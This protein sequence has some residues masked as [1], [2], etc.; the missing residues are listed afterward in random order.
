MNSVVL[1]TISK[2]HFNHHPPCVRTAIFTGWPVPLGKFTCPHHDEHGIQIN[3]RH[4]TQPNRTERQKRRNDTVARSCWSLYLGSRFIR[5]C[6][7]ADSLNFALAICFI[8][9]M[10]VGTSYSFLLSLSF[11]ISRN[12]LDLVC[13][14]PQNQRSVSRPYTTAQ[15]RI[16]E[17]HTREGGVGCV[18]GRA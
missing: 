7:S 1:V 3:E 6:A 9:E 14:P 12:L 8:S 13:A 5:K 15:K 10:A 16:H 2:Q 18:R 17:S 4:R 11:C